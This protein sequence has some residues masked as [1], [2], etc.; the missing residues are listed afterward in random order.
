MAK[1]KYKQKRLRKLRRETKLTATELPTKVINIL[2]TEGIIT[3]E[4]L[5]FCSDD[6]LKGISGIGDKSFIQI[7]EIQNKF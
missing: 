7:K 5:Y 1:G 6:K 2:E 3:L 4:D